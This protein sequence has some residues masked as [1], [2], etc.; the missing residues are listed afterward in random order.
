MDKGGDKYDET[1]RPTDY[2]S[3]DGFLSVLKTGENSCIALVYVT[4][5]ESTLVAVYTHSAN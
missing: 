3:Q 2:S 1:A 4:E 5:A